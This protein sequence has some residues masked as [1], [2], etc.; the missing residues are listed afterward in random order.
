MD[1]V[2]KPSSPEDVIMFK[3]K[4]HEQIEDKS[5]L[6]KRSYEVREDDIQRR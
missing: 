6:R 4:F 3:S 1:K 5:P 2:Q